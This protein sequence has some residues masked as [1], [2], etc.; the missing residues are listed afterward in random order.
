MRYITI[1]SKRSASN[2]MILI[3]SDL[4]HEDMLW[5]FISKAYPMRHLLLELFCCRTLF[6]VGR[7]QDLEK[8]LKSL[9]VYLE[10][11]NESLVCSFNFLL[12]DEQF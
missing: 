5:C 10:Q 4:L 3:C 2:R 6:G 7:R 11:G 12:P 8:V 1:E 9:M